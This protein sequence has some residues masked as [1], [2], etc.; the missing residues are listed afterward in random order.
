MATELF[1]CHMIAQEYKLDP[2]EIYEKWDV[3][4]ITETYSYL[5]WT[6]ENMKKEMDKDKSKNRVGRGGRR[7]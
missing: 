4:Q 3:L 6:D 5:R 1:R 2:H 7:R